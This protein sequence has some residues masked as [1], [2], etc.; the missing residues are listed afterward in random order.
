LLREWLFVELR[1]VVEKSF[2]LGHDELM[3]HGN[4][5]VNDVPG[6][7]LTPV[8][9]ANRRSPL[10]LAGLLLRIDELTAHDE[11]RSTPPHQ[12][13]IRFGLVKLGRARFTA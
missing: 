3:W 5:D 6:S 11:S 4:G 10:L 2:S 8:A 1:Q 12:V 13:Q 7:D 9:A